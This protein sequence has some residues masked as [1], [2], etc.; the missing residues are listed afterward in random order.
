MHSVPHSA[1][2]P[3][4]EAAWLGRSYRKVNDRDAPTIRRCNRFV[5]IFYINRSGGL[6]KVVAIVAGEGGQPGRTL[7]ETAGFMRIFKN[8]KDLAGFGA[9]GPL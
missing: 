2:M 9:D 4:T 5:N 7:Q 1:N 6:I 8:H 3:K